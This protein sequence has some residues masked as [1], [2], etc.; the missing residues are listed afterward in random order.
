MGTVASDAPSDAPRGTSFTEV[1]VREEDRFAGT[2]ASREPDSDFW[3]WDVLFAG[4]PA[5]SPKSF[6]VPLHGVAATGGVASLEVELQGATESRSF[7]EHHVLVSVNGVPVGES[8]FDGLSRHR[9]E[10]SFP[11]RLLREGTNQVELKGL[12]D[13]G[14]LQSIVY[15]DSFALS[16]SKLY[17]A[18]SASF[19]F[20]SEKNEVVSVDGFQVPTVSLLDLSNP[21]R[22]AWVSGTKVEPSASGYRLTFSPP[23]PNAPHL[24]VTP[25]GVKL[26]LAVTADVASQLRSKGNATD[27]LVIAPEELAR[28]ARELARYHRGRGLRTEVVLT[29]DVMDEFHYGIQS[30]HAIRDFL[31]YVHASWRK[32]PR[33]VVLLGKGTYDYKNV[34]GQGDNRLPPLMAAT[35]NGLFASDVRLADVALDDGVPEFAI[36]RIPALS[37]DEV[38]AY[39]ARMREQET[40]PPDSWTRRVLIAADRP[41]NAANFQ[42]DAEALAGLLPSTY[43]ASKVYLSE[44]L[45]I[46]QA[47]ERMFDELEEGTSFLTYVGHGALDRLSAESLLTVADVKSLQNRG[48]RP[49]VTAWTC[50]AGRFDVPG[51]VSL[52]EELVLAN[53]GGASAVWA[54][55]GLSDNV[56]ARWLA[57]E[58]FQTTFQGT[59]ERL[60]DSIKRT[61]ERF[62]ARGASKSMLSIYQL[63]GDPALFIRR[64]EP[65][66]SDTN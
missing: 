8:L 23:T 63:L 1:V 29:E 59:D 56:Q 21:L 24:A 4:G 6:D 49:I 10:L 12:L 51:F 27:Y 45:P 50:N 17:R 43:A 52:G 65:A 16:Y 28:G 40:A 15:V 44:Q 36:G 7:A 62:H 18:D 41:Q 47:R 66:L 11:E 57:E 55:T 31:R 26:P 39:V 33:Y 53:D 48:R 2:M 37:D 42:S 64:P 19:R 5:S 46:E 20:G 60:G 32:R 35:D 54:P 9:F 61:F 3:F 22:P 58:F 34:L 14:V 38:I 25:S 13:E 30:P